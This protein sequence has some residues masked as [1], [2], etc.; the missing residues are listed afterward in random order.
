MALPLENLTNADLIPNTRQVMRIIPQT[1]L[2]PAL[3]RSLHLTSE[4][5]SGC[6]KKK[7]KSISFVGGKCLLTFRRETKTGVQEHS[8]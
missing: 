4:Y 2:E 7:K 8:E 5:L 6:K 1:T 3:K